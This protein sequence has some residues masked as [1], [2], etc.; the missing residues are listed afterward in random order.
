MTPI[1]YIQ[2]RF[3]QGLDAEVSKLKTLALT[4]DEKARKHAHL[5]QS[6]IMGLMMSLS[7]VNHGI[8]TS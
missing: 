4:D 2:E 6:L 1:N 3:R 8:M 7:W 5:N